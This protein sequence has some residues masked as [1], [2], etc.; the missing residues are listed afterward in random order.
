MWTTPA[1]QNST[2]RLDQSCQSQCRTHMTEGDL[3]VQNL[4]VIFSSADQSL[5]STN[6]LLLK[7]H[8]TLQAAMFMLLINMYLLISSVYAY[9]IDHQFSSPAC[10]QGVLLNM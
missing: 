4:S 1:S 10:Q 7:G 6:Q 2:P 3:S 8:M 9:N 5:D